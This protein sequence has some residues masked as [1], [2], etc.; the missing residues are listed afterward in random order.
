M[1]IYVI[2]QGD[3]WILESEQVPKKWS[4]KLSREQERKKFFEV[5]PVRKHALIKDHWLILTEPDG[6]PYTI[7]LKGCIIEAV[8]ATNMPSR[9]WAKRYPIKMQSKTSA[10]YKGSKTLY[11]YLDT[12]WDKE[13][14]CKALRLAS[15]D[16]H[17]RLSWFS[18]LHEEYKS[19]VSTLL[20][21]YPSF[22]RPQSGFYT[23]PIDKENRLDSSSSKV[24]V[25]WKKLAKKVSK[26]AAENNKSAW[27]SLSGREERRM[28]E[29][30]R[31]YQ[32]SISSTSSGSAT[33]LPG[34]P[35]RNSSLPRSRSQSNI[36][37]VSD[38]DPDDRISVDE[39][40]LCWNLLVSRLF[41]DVKKSENIRR[42]IQDRIQRTLSNMRTPNYIG[43]VI[44]TNIDLGSL[45]PHIHSMRV[46]P[47]DMTEIWAFEIDLEYSGGVVMDIET[48]IEVQ[49]LDLQKE[50]VDPNSESSVLLEEFEQLGNQL[51]I[52][53]EKSDQVDQKDEG[54][55]RVDEPK[56]SKTN[57][58]SSAPNVK[59]RW[60]SM[61]NSVAKQVSQVPLSLRIRVAS[62]RGTIRFHVKPP[63]SDQLWFC[64]TSM[65]DIDFNLESSVGEHK[66]SSSHVAL[67]LINRFKA[68]MREIMVA[69][70]SESVWI[71]FMVAENDDWIPRNTAP[72]IWLKPDPAPVL[73]KPSSS[74]PVDARPNTSPARESSR[75]HSESRPQLPKPTKSE[76]AQTTA[77]SSSSDASSTA[78]D[79]T[80]QKQS[81]QDPTTPLLMTNDEDQEERIESREFPVSESS[82]RSVS[83]SPSRSVSMSSF[84]SQNSLN[85]E[86]DGKPK[87]MGR[88]A[89]MLDLRKKMG[90]KIE[91]KRRH[92]EEKGRTIVEKMRAP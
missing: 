69:P 5:S 31:G 20:D 78:A 13:S 24:R 59:S 79:I 41:F 42:S 88:R 92:I 90:E 38:S 68:S 9:K 29:R 66:I 85:S 55:S 40:T 2:F 64:F 52:S 10:I 14:W 53:N 3:I 60:K 15:C 58:T 51:N 61:L 32:D 48:R 30:V 57:A 50:L 82:S 35:P 21:G 26:A 89:R 6:S 86:D 39:G 65:P 63:P 77:S 87:K 43:E 1:W 28:N 46:L 75:D 70:N 91:E 83:Q 49:E 56:I 54:D 74:Q 8:S 27:A 22:M 19:Y 37:V 12:S 23:E 4:E 34:L 36:S 17:M 18:K 7:Q 45:P 25:I 33:P 76:Q 72:F 47:L 80:K 71:P 73:E 84:G 16:D 62:L 11:I 81:S 44:C 67:F